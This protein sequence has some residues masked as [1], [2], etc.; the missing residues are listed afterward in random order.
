MLSY[1]HQGDR[2][3]IKTQNHLN[4]LYHPLGCLI[5]YRKYVKSISILSDNENI[6]KINI[7]KN[8][9]NNI[10]ILNNVQ[11]FLKV[12][13]CDDISLKKYNSSFKQNHKKPELSNIEISWLKLFGYEK[14]KF[15][16]YDF[17]NVL[18]SAI[19]IPT[20]V[21]NNIYIL[22]SEIVHI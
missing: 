17:F 1:K 21:I 6:F 18:F 11:A 3:D 20:W 19:S 13:V 8:E 22:K 7:L 2:K 15:N 5:V 12:K 14:S 9:E 4:K 10:Q 16:V